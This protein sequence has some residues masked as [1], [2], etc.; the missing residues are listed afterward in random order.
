MGVVLRKS[1]GSSSVVFEPFKPYVVSQVQL[2]KIMGDENLK[3]RVFKITDLAPRVK[4][5]HV[6]ARS[7]ST[8]SLL[9]YAGSGG[10]G[11]QILAWPF[12]HILSKMGFEIHIMVD[13]GNEMCWW[14]FPWVKSIV[15]VPMPWE[16][17]KLYSYHVLFETCANHDEHPD[18]L[19]PVDTMLEK[20][21]IPHLSINPDQKA[22]RPAFFPQEIARV[23]QFKPD[24][25]VALYQLAAS[26][27]VRSLPADESAFLLGCLAQEFPDWTWIGLYDEFVHETYH[28]AATDLKLPNVEVATFSVLRD[29]WILAQRA[30]VIVS[31]DSMM[32]HVAGTSGIPCVG[33]WGPTSPM[34]RVRYYRHHVPVFPREKCPISPCFYTGGVFPA[35]CPPSTVG[36]TA[37]EVLMGV[38]PQAVFDAV[39]TA[40]A[41]KIEAKT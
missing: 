26:T 33:L 10:Y 5:F 2:Q 32:T 39:K 22:V 18:Q 27:P 41:S 35:Y 14:C 37:C 30:E 16:Q 11:D 24:A 21:G 3:T 7:S 8:Q 4:N 40:R 25:K 36:R 20:V 28:N 34:H 1:A 31:P 15:T 6:A 17:F 19:H 13:P 38:K 29:L 9:L 12:A 23:R